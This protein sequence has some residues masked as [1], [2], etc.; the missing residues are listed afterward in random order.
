MRK[1][2]PSKSQ[3]KHALYIIRLRL[4]T[5]LGYAFSLHVSLLL[6]VPLLVV[7]FSWFHKQPMQIE[8]KPENQIIQAQLVMM[9][10]KPEVVKKIAPIKKVK[11]Q[12][13]PKPKPKPKPAPVK[14]AK[15]PKKKPI[16]KPQAKP[17]PKPKVVAKST[18]PP[19]QVQKPKG[20]S[21]Q[22][23]AEIAKKKAAQARF[24]SWQNQQKQQAMLAIQHK[25]SANWINL[26][27][28]KKVLV[29]D[30]TID[31]NTQTGAVEEVQVAKSS[32]DRAFDN[33]AMMAVRRATPL[34]L[35]ENPGLA[36]AFSV[37]KLSFNNQDKA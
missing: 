21:K 11:L 35:P 18:P 30:L 33:Q 4:K 10:P 24:A 37:I 20:P 26:Y 3:L 5:P 2:L 31:V 15:L 16:A 34:P 9:A 25:I 28:Q 19:K 36:N 17:K 22:E 8:I 1:K 32:G 23:L 14:V 7:I 27:N 29:V 6:V 13:K 12:P